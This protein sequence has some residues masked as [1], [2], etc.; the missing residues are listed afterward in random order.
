MR[1]F[2]I[3]LYFLFSPKDFCDKN[4]KEKCYKQTCTFIQPV[5]LQEMRTHFEALYT[6]VSLL[7]LKIKSFIRQTDGSLFV[8][9]Q[10]HATRSNPYSKTKSLN[11]K[12]CYY[13]D[14]I[15]SLLCFFLRKLYFLDLSKAC[16]SYNNAFIC[17]RVLFTNQLNR[18]LINNK[19]LLTLIIF[20]YTV[21][22]SQY[23]NLY[24]NFSYIISFIRFIDDIASHVF[25]DRR[26][27]HN[28]IYILYIYVK[29]YLGSPV[30]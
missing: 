9:L 4:P 12:L 17:V 3:L 7:H 8:S 27:T 23:I 20:I 1:V 21:R 28:D 6:F 25:H 10:I 29:V 5:L 30:F 2:R 14:E 26:G 15:Y 22:C 24:V 11:F 13:F 18:F 19:M 16:K